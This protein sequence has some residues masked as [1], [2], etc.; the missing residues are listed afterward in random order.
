MTDDPLISDL[1]LEADNE[2]REPPGPALIVPSVAATGCELLAHEEMH[3]TA[4][5]DFP[6]AGE[7]IF[8]ELDEATGAV[9]FANAARW[10]VLMSWPRLPTI[11]EADQWQKWA[12][13]RCLAAWWD[14]LRAASQRAETG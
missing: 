1:S 6:G 2:G 11:E 9:D 4:A 3:R 14:R 5:R 12:E 13:A 10:Q 8:E 7:V